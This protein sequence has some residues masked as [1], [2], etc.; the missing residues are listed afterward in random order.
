[1]IKFDGL[2]SLISLGLAIFS[3]MVTNFINKNDFENY[4]FGKYIVEPLL[5]I[6]KSTILL[7]TCSYTMLSSVKEIINGGNLVNEEVALGYSLISSIGC[8]LVYLYM[9]KSSKNLNSEIVNIESKQWFMDT[10]LSFG[11]LIGFIIGIIFKFI[12]LTALSNYID[13]SMVLITS[14]IFLRMPI[15]SILSSLKE[16]TNSSIDEDINVDINKLI[17]KIEKEYNIDDTIIRI[18][19]IG[20]ELR[21]EIDFIV[22]DSSRVKSIEDMDKVREIID[23]NTNHFDLKKWL[24]ISFTKNKKWAI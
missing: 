19:K 12:G 4:P 5:V 10:I 24:N 23:K 13:P 11:V 9:K 16:I 2:Y 15:E 8:M 22:S 7:M 3:I 18:A 1:M 21:I 6:F 14:L 20:R 17:K